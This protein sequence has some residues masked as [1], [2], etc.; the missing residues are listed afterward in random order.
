MDRQ[1]T[2]LVI[3]DDEQLRRVLIFC[4]KILGHYVFGTGDFKE[5]VDM[6]RKAK[7]TNIDL[8]VLD[9]SLN[10]QARPEP[11]SLND[12]EKIAEILRKESQELKI[13]GLSAAEVSYGDINFKKPCDFADLKKAVSD[14]F[15]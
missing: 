13:I 11:K 10:K 1:L 4:F 7:E 12:G 9:S 3:E 2:I 15:P 14:L 5:A 8:V 6:A